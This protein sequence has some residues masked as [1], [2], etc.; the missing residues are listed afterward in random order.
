MEVGSRSDGSQ[1]PPCPTVAWECGGVLCW[2]WVRGRT[3]LSGISWWGR[4]DTLPRPFPAAE[5]WDGLGPHQHLAWSWVLVWCPLPHS[6]EPSPSP[7]VWGVCFRRHPGLLPDPLV[8][9]CGQEPQEEILG[10]R[11]KGGRRIR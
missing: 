7:L 5:F 2:P 6:P 4:D 10:P 11:V 3:T 8:G 1:K 9:L